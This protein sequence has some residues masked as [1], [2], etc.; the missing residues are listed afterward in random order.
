MIVIPVALNSALVFG[1]S[2]GREQLKDLSSSYPSPAL[3]S[4][5]MASAK[6]REYYCF[7]LLTYFR[8]SALGE[9]VNSVALALLAV[10]VGI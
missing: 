7:V 8:Q 9:R 3:Q 2:A 1:T 6:A 5:R 10:R 4:V